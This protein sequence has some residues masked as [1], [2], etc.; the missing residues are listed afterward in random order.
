MLSWTFYTQCVTLE[1]QV[2]K[3][4][5]I[6]QDSCVMTNIPCCFRPVYRKYFGQ[7]ALSISQAS[8][9][10]FTTPVR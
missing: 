8:L 7:Y 3:N 10:A 4:V 1:K 5:L 6:V 9:N 2:Q